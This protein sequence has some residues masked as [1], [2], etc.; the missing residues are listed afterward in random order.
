MRFDKQPWVSEFRVY[1]SSES[2]QIGCDYSLGL[3]SIVRSRG[4]EALRSDCLALPFKSDFA[5]AVIN[6]AVIHHLSTFVSKSF[7]SFI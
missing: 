2:F 4:F 5:D 6:I 1:A 3:A 7:V